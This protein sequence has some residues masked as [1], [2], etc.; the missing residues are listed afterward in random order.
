VQ[1]QL[2]LL[3]QEGQQQHQEAIAEA[4]PATAASAAGPQT[5]ASPAAF[6]ADV[7]AA[8]VP[9]VRFCPP[10]WHLVEPNP[11]CQGSSADASWSAATRPRMAHHCPDA[12]KMLYL[13]LLP[14]DRA[15]S[16]CTTSSGDTWASTSGARAL[17]LCTLRLLLDPSLLNGAFTWS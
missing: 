14:K 10:C 6:N 7:A 13:N 15:A 4:A 5:A 16:T 9:A 8:A 11:P 3:L 1:Q 2:L 17:L 12:P